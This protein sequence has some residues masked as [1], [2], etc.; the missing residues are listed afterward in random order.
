MQ[1]HTDEAIEQSLSDAF[2]HDDY[3]ERKRR[4]AIEN[5]KRELNHNAETGEEIRLNFWPFNEP[6]V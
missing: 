4:E 5:L 3:G 1:K 2:G 6:P